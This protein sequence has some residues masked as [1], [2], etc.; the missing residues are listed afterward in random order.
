[1][2]LNEYMEQNNLTHE[3]FAA[4]IGCHRSAVTRWATGSRRPSP[5][6]L[7][8]I[9]RKTKGLVTAQELLGG[10]ELEAVIASKGFTLRAAAQKLKISRNV[11][12]GY[13]KSRIAVTE[14]HAARIQRLFG[15]SP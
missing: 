3:D 8:I 11:L 15:V 7:R 2:T 1:M 10:S 14:E 13:A 5:V 9:V 4:S 12:A 6:W